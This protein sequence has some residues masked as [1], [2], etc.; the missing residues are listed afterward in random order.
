MLEEIERAAAE[1]GSILMETAREGP[2]IRRK[3]ARELVTTADIRSEEF[4]RGRL[5][6][7]IPG[8]GFMG[9]ESSSGGFP[10]PPFWIVDPLDGTNNYA[11][12]F[13]M[14]S[15][16]I[17]LWEGDRVAFGCVHDPLRRETF[18]AEAGCGATLNGSRVSC[19]RRGDLSD[20]LVA[21]GFPYSRKEGDPGVDLG[22]LAYFLQR[23]QGV[24]RGGSAALD[25]SYVASGRLDGFYEQ[26]LKP[27]DMAAGCL[28]V[29]ESGGKVTAYQGGAWTL[30]SGGVLASGPVIHD[31]MRRG[32][33]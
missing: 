18:S 14:F 31:A 22:V 33:P 6:E 3:S 8:A 30:S 26:S 5:S 32:I 24:R 10:D 20:C 1:A 2:D 15:V 16:S 17:A 23:V 29:M 4:L 13:P 11:H 7:I 19:T 21:T 12:G 28:L 9:E 25:L 27:W